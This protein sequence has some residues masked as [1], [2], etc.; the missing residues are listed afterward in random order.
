MG[1]NSLL[2]VFGAHYSFTSRS[3]VSVWIMH[4]SSLQRFMLCTTA[5]AVSTFR[6]L[7]K[8]QSDGIYFRGRD[9]EMS[10]FVFHPITHL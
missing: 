9:E 5:L 1:L 10:H 2:V 6:L 3:A 8:G 4:N 7:R